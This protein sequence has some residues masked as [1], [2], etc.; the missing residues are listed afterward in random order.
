MLLKTDEADEV[1]NVSEN[2]AKSIA[3]MFFLKYYFDFGLLQLYSCEIF[4]ENVFKYFFL[5]LC[6]VGL[7]ER[8][9]RSDSEC[10]GNKNSARQKI[11]RNIY[12]E[13]L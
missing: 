10:L 3:H 4:S 9:V 2:K 11:I 12:S 5:T 1:F 7:G 6:A 8:N 13:I